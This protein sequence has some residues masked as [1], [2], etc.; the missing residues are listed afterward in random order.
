ML[1]TVDANAQFELLVRSVRNLK[2]FDSLKQSKGHAANLTCMYLPITDWQARDNHV[3][4]TNRLHLQ[5]NRHL[6]SRNADPA[7]SIRQHGKNSL[8]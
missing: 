2:C 6:G 1:T 4:I 3:G 7:H 5:D 8:F